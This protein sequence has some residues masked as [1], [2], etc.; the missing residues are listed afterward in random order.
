MK[1]TIDKA[2]NI[3]WLIFG[4]GGYLNQHSRNI[5]Y[6]LSKLVQ[7]CINNGITKFDTASSYSYGLDEYRF[8]KILNT[9]A[10]LC[11]ITSK[12]GFIK[13]PLQ[14]FFANKK[15]QNFSESFIFNSLNNSC[16]NLRRNSIDNYLLHSPPLNEIENGLETLK[17]I[18]FKGLVHNIGFS[19]SNL[20]NIFEYLKFLNLVDVIQIPCSTSPEFFEKIYKKVEGTNTKLVIR[21][22]FNC[23]QLWPSVDKNFKKANYGLFLKH[24]HLRWPELNILFSSGKESH[25]Q[26]M[27]HQIN[28]KNPYN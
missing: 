14:K 15:R 10:N 3:P 25:L 12:V 20:D 18:K 9:K 2:K 19:T 24:I 4:S 6:S 26:E 16:N 22:T 17:K 27:L 23:W 7:I 1:L 8:G 11:E 13:S 28:I 5:D 21:N